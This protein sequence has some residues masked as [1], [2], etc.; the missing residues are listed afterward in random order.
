MSLGRKNPGLQG[1]RERSCAGESLY[2]RSVK[3]PIRSLGN[4]VLKYSSKSVQ[5]GFCCFFHESRN[6]SRLLFGRGESSKGCSEGLEG[7]I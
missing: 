2:H 7:F 1:V 3:L 5:K 6:W 4:E